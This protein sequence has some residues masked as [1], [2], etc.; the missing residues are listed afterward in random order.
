VKLWNLIENPCGEW[1]YYALNEI[2]K[3]FFFANFPSGYFRPLTS[4]MTPQ[5]IEGVR[6]TGKT[7]YLDRHDIEKTSTDNYIGVYI[8]RRDLRAMPIPEASYDP[9]MR[10]AQDFFLE[11]LLRKLAQKMWIFGYHPDQLKNTAKFGPALSRALRDIH[12]GLLASKEDEK[13]L[14][15]TSIEDRFCHAVESIARNT[16]RSIYFLIDDISELA[17][18]QQETVL[19]EIKILRELRK[20]VTFKLAGE[21]GKIL[22]SGILK[23]VHD[24]EVSQVRWQSYRQREYKRFIGEMFCRRALYYSLDDSPWEVSLNEIADGSCRL[25]LGKINEIR[26]GYFDEASWQLLLEGSMSIPRYFLQLA[27]NAF[28]LASSKPNVYTKRSDE[29]FVIN[30]KAVRQALIDKG[31]SL[32]EELRSYG[33]NSLKRYHPGLGPQDVRNLFYGIR[34][35]LASKDVRRGDKEVESASLFLLNP[36]ARN[37]RLSDKAQAALDFLV[38]EG[39]LHIYNPRA[40]KT[41]GYSAPAYVLDRALCEFYKIRFSLSDKR[42]IHPQALDDFLL[43]REKP[44]QEVPTEQ[45]KLF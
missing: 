21:F 18:L 41:G 14:Y 19:T 42:Q 17:E 10:R 24:V 20:D 29:R 9:S 45:L 36:G 40:T 16:G 39:I 3:I 12:D 11:I 30:E 6:G 37:V 38:D 5:I 34:H 13:E 44:R 27:R 2:Q 15:Q 4:T 35:R 8:S 22:W 23:G 26:N 33:Q 1:D 28:D 43:H 31:K 7:S 32:D 25:T